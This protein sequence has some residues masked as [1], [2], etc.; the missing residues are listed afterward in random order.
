MVPQDSFSSCM[1]MHGIPLISNH[2]SSLAIEALTV[3]QSSRYRDRFHHLQGAQSKPAMLFKDA[4]SQETTADG[5]N[6]I[7]GCRIPTFTHT[8]AAE[9][10]LG[11]IEVMAIDDA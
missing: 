9:W 8:K 11:A 3:K 6:A 5:L 2:H 4:A 10:R 1:A 7:R